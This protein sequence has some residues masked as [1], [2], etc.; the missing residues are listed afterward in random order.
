MEAAWLCVVLSNNLCSQGPLAARDEMRRLAGDA[1][2]DFRLVDDGFDGECY[3]FLKC[4]P[5]MLNME[6]LRQSKRVTNVLSSYN[7]PSYLKDDEVYGF[8]VDEDV[9][10]LE[11]MSYGDIVTVIGDGPFTGL[12][13]VVVLAGCS[14][15]FVLFRFHTLSNHQWIMREE[16]QV[17]GNVFDWLKFPVTEDSFCQDGKYPVL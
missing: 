16:L 11:C 2:V 5:D 7:E 15:S 6:P 13:G 14:E 1:F 8:V 3:S 9:E 12:K 4:R 10:A 17:D